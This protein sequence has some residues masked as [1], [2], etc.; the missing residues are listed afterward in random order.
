VFNR[1]HFLKVTFTRVED[2]RLTALE[3]GISIYS[4][5]AGKT[6]TLAGQALAQMLSCFLPLLPP[7]CLARSPSGSSRH[8]LSCSPCRDAHGRGDNRC[9]PPAKLGQVLSPCM[10]GCSQSKDDQP[11]RSQQYEETEKCK[12][13]AQHYFCRVM[14]NTRVWGG[15]FPG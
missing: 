6:R 5:G 4:Q 12:R 13:E 8:W 9:Q 7:P 11:T 2:L 14:H 1:C 10:F 15:L 3:A